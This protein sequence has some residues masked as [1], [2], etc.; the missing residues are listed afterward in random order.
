MRRYPSLNAGLV[1]LALSLWPLPAHPEE[2]AQF[3]QH[4]NYT[5][6]RGDTLWRIA[7]VLFGKAQIY[8]SIWAL[9]NDD[10]LNP[11]LIYP[12]H[13]LHFRRLNPN[14]AGAHENGRQSKPTGVLLPQKGLSM[15][16]RN[17]P[18]QDWEKYTA[19]I[20][21]KT[22]SVALS[23]PKKLSIRRHNSLDPDF[24]PSTHLIEPVGVVLDANTESR[25]LSL[26]DL[27]YIKPNG[28]L[29]IG[30]SYAV[31]TDPAELKNA[32]N[33]RVGY[34]YGLL[35]RVKIVAARGKVFVA[36]VVSSKFAFS[37]G[38]I[39]LPLPPSI[40]LLKPITGPQP[41]TARVLVDRTFSTFASAQHKVVFVDRGSADGLA[42]GM[43]FRIFN[44]PP[45]SSGK[46]VDENFLFDRQLMVLQVS[47]N[48]STVMILGGRDTVEEF[49]SA[50]LLTDLADV[51]SARGY[52]VLGQSA[53]PSTFVAPPI[54]QSLEATAETS[55]TAAAPPGL[56]VAPAPVADEL[57]P[58]A[59]PEAQTPSEAGQAMPP[60]L[61]DATAPEFSVTPPGGSLKSPAAAAESVLLN[62]VPLSPG[63][64]SS[65][66]DGTN[67]VPIAPPTTP[68]TSPA[69]P[70]APTGD[71]NAALP[72]LNNAPPAN[73]AIPPALGDSSEP[74]GELPPP[75]PAFKD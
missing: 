31:T 51:N 26:L 18:R 53:S 49:T 27:V 16:W 45:G 44:Q 72:W 63:D 8:P 66:P 70:T 39:V 55:Q 12:N 67:P 37:R 14:A 62:P 58:I 61:L 10:I 7:E 59:P 9:N 20:D 65:A 11:N 19:S 13:V 38:S 23:D 28:A 15:D 24:I 50:T 30:R 5:I 64:S 56:P 68:D 36:R 43:I 35:A 40:P 17:A 33:D 47:E 32:D 25:V 6:K 2:I 54:S 73:A 48:V 1:S 46:T 21:A 22:A 52:T 69:P 42:P 71:P 3:E 29:E 57:A 75:P 60:P 34:S 74:A 4:E 41:I